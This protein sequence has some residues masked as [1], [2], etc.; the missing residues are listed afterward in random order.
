[1]VESVVRA[2]YIALH[3]PQ[4]R[5]ATD[6]AGGRLLIY[7]PDMNLAHGLEESETRGFVDIDNIPPWDTWIDYVIEAKANYLLSWVPGPLVTLVTDGIAVSPEMC[8]R[9]LDDTDFELRD[10]LKSCGVAAAR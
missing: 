7:E 1:V 3:H 4:K 5:L 9:F 10:R 6:L 8:F 2:R